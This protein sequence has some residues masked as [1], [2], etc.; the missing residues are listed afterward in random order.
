MFV[1][2]GISTTCGIF[3][4]SVDNVSVASVCSPLTK[5][6]S[7]FSD[8]H[9][10]NYAGVGVDDLLISQPFVS[11]T[12][13]GIFADG[14]ELQHKKGHYWIG[15]RLSKVHYFLALTMIRVPFR[16]IIGFVQIH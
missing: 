8:Y 2:A 6:K 9:T 1:G 10:D 16:I 15:S 11:G 4:T 7:T 5:N 13:S 14:D 3:S 12:G